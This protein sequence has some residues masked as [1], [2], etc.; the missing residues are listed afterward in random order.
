MV[1]DRVEVP[2]HRADL[3]VHE[4]Q[5]LVDEGSLVGVLPEEPRV[6]GQGRDLKMARCS[7]RYHTRLV[8]FE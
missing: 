2:P 7:F 6:R 4:G 3:V 5:P 1:V 8:E